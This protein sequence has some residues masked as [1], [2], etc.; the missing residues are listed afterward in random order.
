MTSKAT[1]SLRGHIQRNNHSRGTNSQ[2]RI[3]RS[4][5]LH[6]L[7]VKALDFG[8]RGPGSNPISNKVRNLHSTCILKSI[9]FAKYS[10]MHHL[11]ILNPLLAAGST[12]PLPSSFTPLLK[13]LFPP[14]HRS[15]HQKGGGK[16][17][18]STP[19]QK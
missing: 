11:L 16:I 4:F 8:A 6:S 13:F 1:D 5:L 15:P 19:L 10:L 14:L 9:H 7:V 17:R 18:S 3:A 2:L 12:G